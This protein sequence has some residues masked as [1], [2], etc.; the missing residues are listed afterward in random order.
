MSFGS[1]SL[2][3]FGGVGDMVM[4]SGSSITINDGLG[5][6]TQASC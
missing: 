1:S 4:V 6:D 5:K 3:D 2:S